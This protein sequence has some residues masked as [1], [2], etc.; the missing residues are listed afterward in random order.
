MDSLTLTSSVFLHN[1]NIPAA[2]TCEGE[3]KN[4]PLDISGVP[5][6]AKSLA[7]IVDDPDAPVGTWDHWILWNIAPDTKRIDQGQLPAGAVQGMNDFK[8]TNYGGP[9][10]PPGKPHRY[11]FKLYALDESLDLTSSS[12]KQDLE[13]A[14]E[15]HILTRAE[16]IGLYQR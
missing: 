16:L 7:L 6:T 15:G 12:T 11:F 14:M 13:K 10:P 5:Q 9:C 4:P 8:K 3:D 1:T 2:Y